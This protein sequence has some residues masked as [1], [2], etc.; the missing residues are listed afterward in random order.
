MDVKVVFIGNILMGDDG[1]GPY[2]YNELKD[3]PKLKEV[4]MY[5]LGVIGLDLI[6]FIEKDDRLVIVDAVYSKG[7]IGEV[8]LLREKDLSKDLKLVS[9]H[10]F[11][12]EQ[13]STILR[14]YQ[15]DL[16]EIKI[17]GIKV[18]KIN[19]ISD[20]L[21]DGLMKKIPKIKERVLS[22]ILKIS[23]ED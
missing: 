6:N 15:P 18:D 11:G 12:V 21:S 8:V 22:Y 20:K 5:E 17:I 3:Y 16:K 23:K 7:N 13:T 10:D 14:M 4:K 2:L 1:I 9:M 19:R